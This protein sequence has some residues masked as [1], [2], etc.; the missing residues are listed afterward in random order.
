[1]V[2][3][4]MKKIKKDKGFTIVELLIVIVVI[5]ILAAITIV[6]YGGITARAN[7][8]KAQTNTANTQ[9]V[10]EAFNAD[11]GFYPSTITT[12]FATGS[13]ST[14][15]P[16]GITIIKGP[17]GAESAGVFTTA[18]FTAMTTALASE[19]PVKTVAYSFVGTAGAATGG[20]IIS[21]DYVAGAISTTYTYVGGAS[22]TSTFVTPAS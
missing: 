7:N 22:A 18:Q 17:S 20:V 21:W 8:A 19:N 9:K 6:A 16:S 15:L 2:L 13:L 3:S 5:A 4:K 12:D 10:A 14:K 11:K 1:M